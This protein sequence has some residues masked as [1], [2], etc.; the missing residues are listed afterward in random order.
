MS[1]L[2][3]VVAPLL[4]CG[5]DELRPRLAARSLRATELSS[6]L[7]QVA[8]AR[9]AVTFAVHPRQQVPTLSVAQLIGL[10]EGRS[11]S[12]PD[13]VGVRLLANYA[14]RSGLSR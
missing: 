13:G 5:L 9:A 7:A 12:W 2:A 4:D 6:E 8:L 1:L 10:Y 14:L 11:A 3:L